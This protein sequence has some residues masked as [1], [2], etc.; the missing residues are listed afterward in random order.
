MRYLGIILATMPAVYAAMH[1]FLGWFP[2]KIYG[3][4]AYV[5]CGAVFLVGILLIV[6]SPKTD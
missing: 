1:Y 4:D 5:C 2:D 3:F 6:T